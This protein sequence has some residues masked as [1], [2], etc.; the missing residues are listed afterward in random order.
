[1]P[2]WAIV[3]SNARALPD[4]STA[5][6]CTAHSAVY[7]T[8]K[9][10]R[11]LVL[12][13][14]TRITIFHGRLHQSEHRSRLA[15]SL[16]LRPLYRHRRKS[17][18]GLRVPKGFQASA[19]ITLNSP[20]PASAFTRDRLPPDVGQARRGYPRNCNRSSPLRPSQLCRGGNLARRER[21]RKDRVGTWR[22]V[23]GAH[24]D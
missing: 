3:D 11:I 2:W 5:A 7:D 24:F 16:G 6:T 23:F 15:Q 22:V 13:L 18:L 14:N 1:M 4:Q 12:P 21:P 19:G 8:A 10:V 9:R 20:N 17:P